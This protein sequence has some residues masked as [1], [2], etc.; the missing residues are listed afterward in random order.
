MKTI[1]MNKQKIFSTTLLMVVAFLGVFLLISCSGGGGTTSTGA[2]SAVTLT[3]IKLTTPNNNIAVGTSAKI[4]ATGTYSDNSTKDITKLVN[5]V[6]LENN[7]VEL[8]H[9]NSKVKGKNSGQALILGQ[10][11]GVK[12]SSLPIT[13]ENKN[14]QSISINPT[15]IANIMETYTQQFHVIA[16]YS[17]GTTQDVTDDATWS[18]ESSAIATCNSTGKCSVLTN[19][20]TNVV[21]EFNNLTASTTVAMFPINPTANYNIM[22]YTSVSASTCSVGQIITFSALI[23]DYEPSGVYVGYFPTG[24]S[25]IMVTPAYGGQYVQNIVVSNNSTLSY[26]CIAPGTTGFYIENASG[27]NGVQPGTATVVITP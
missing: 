14:L 2:N 16:N 17:D 7:V 18:T 26:K 5:L 1:N 27:A 12:A 4:I 19:G 11:N 24:T 25:G 9:A 8:D 10:Y 23:N 3:G 22:L 13:V 21:A 6:A 20:Q 15:N